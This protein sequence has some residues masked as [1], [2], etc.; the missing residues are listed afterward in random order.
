VWAPGPVDVE[1]PLRQGDLIQGFFL[2][3]LRMPIP[4]VAE[5]GIEL[6]RTVQMQVEARRGFALVV[7]QCCSA[8][9]SELVALANVRPQRVPD[10]RTRR[11]LLAT[12]PPE[13]PEDGDYGYV[14]GLF[15]LAPILGLLDESESLCSVADLNHIQSFGGNLREIR[16]KRVVRMTPEG[17]EFL[18]T[19]LTFFWA[20][21]EAED[22]AWLRERDTRA[23]GAPPAIERP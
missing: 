20:R 10:E 21:P 18:R 16:A 3:R 13:E 6:P 9:N 17:R 4:V 5:P 8:E 22:E 23:A 2:P 14:Y 11:A 12:Q 1:E 15:R 7:S 19:K